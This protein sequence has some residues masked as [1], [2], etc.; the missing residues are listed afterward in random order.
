M[1]NKI[2]LQFG[3]QQFFFAFKG[4]KFFIKNQ[5]TFRYFIIISFYEV[6]LDSSFSDSLEMY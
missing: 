2:Y 1:S 6:K 4:K 5:E 3:T